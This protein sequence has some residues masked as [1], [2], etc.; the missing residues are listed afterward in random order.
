MKILILCGVFSDV[1]TKEI[2]EKATAPVEFSA[3]NMQQKLIKGFESSECELSVI[4]APFIGTFPTSSKIINFKGFKEPCNEYKYVK[5]NNVWGIRNFSRAKALIK[6]MD[7]FINDGDPDKAIIIYHAHTPFIKAG[8][9]AKE[10]DPNIKLC[11]YVT[12]LPQYMNLSADRG[13]IYNMAKT[14]DNVTMTKLMKK[15]D[16]FVLLTE[17]M[18]E[19]LPVDDKLYMIVEGIID[20]IPE[21]EDYQYDDGLKYVVYT[22]KLYEEFGVKNLID[23][24]RYIDNSDYRLI[25]CGTGDCYDY[26][27]KAKEKDNRICPLGQ[28]N[29]EEAIKWQKKAT[30]LVN[31]RNNNSEYTKYSFPSK[32]IEYLLTGKPVIGYMLDGM[33]EIYKSFINVLEPDSDEGASMANKII[34]VVSVAKGEVREENLQY[35]EY[36]RNMISASVIAQRIIR[37]LES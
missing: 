34:D 22:G 12:D 5:F 2:L 3:N 13:F 14:I 30:V 25:L 1:N 33:P 36:A 18:K 4:S 23:S 24:F 9:Y 17:Q 19:K 7:S 10:K 16:A 29:P 32:N 27:L 20:D 11:L 35:L 8:V 37:L 28:V 26:A 15:V 6:A 31:P 21:I